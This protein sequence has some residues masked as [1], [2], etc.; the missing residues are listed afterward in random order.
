MNGRKHLMMVTTYLDYRKAFNTKPHERLIEKIK[1]NGNL[2]KWIE[3]FLKDRKTRVKVN[4]SYS[5]WYEVWSGVPQGSV[6][7]PLCSYYL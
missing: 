4:G 2:L 6:L 7:G 1:R 3:D 5:A